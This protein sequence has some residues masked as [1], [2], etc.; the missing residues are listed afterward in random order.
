[1]RSHLG[2]ID[3]YNTRAADPAGWKENVYAGP[4][5]LE[6]M[7]R[8]KPGNVVAIAGKN[9][10]K[11]DYIRRSVGAGLNVLADKPMVITTA[12]FDSL[13]R[14]F[15]EARKNKVLLYDIMTERY[16]ITNM[17]QRELSRFPDVFGELK[18][19]SPEDP[20][21]VA[22]SVHYFYK[23]VSGSPLIRPA[24]YFDVRQQ[25][26]GIVDVTT[27]LVDLVQWECFPETVLS[28]KK[29]IKMLSARHW[30]TELTP[31]QFTRVTKDES[32]PDFLRGDITDGML[33][34]Y[35]NGEMNYTIKGVHTRV[36]VNW[37]Y[38]APAGTGD[39]YYSLL[40]GSKANLVIRQGREQSYKPVL[41]IIP[42]SANDRI[43]W[44]KAFASGLET[45]EKKYP[46]VEARKEAAG[47]KLIIPEKYDI[48]HEQQFA[49][50]FK[51]YISYLLKGNMPEWE[52][53]GML[54]K[55]YTLTEALKK[56]VQ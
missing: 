51:K 7:L 27:H 41:Y 23:E 34:V 53:K 39:T 18:K 45:I 46:G 30:A 55:Y 22:E 21:I 37:K 25:G 8:E 38:E 10:E 3:R 6:K 36:S 31:V 19:G 24:W 42:D 4:D 50:V 35:A 44:E 1:L 40:R 28:Y 13:K 56:A 9:Q 2:L 14:A 26:E 32:Y 48:G 33:K 52:I 11:T 16:E 17:L 15:A 49:L 20:A 54:A 47:W 12:G 29:D 43:Q 5:Y